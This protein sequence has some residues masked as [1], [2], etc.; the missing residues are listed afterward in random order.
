MQK[1]KTLT[2]QVTT[3]IHQEAIDIVNH[4]S[5]GLR[6]AQIAGK[7]NFGRR[8]IEFKIDQL[9]KDYGCLTASHLVAVFIRNKIIE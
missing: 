6:P 9:R 7:M 3:E 2:L 1:S 4:L 8:T 5:Y